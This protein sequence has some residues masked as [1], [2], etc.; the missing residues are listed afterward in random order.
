MRGRPV[1][2]VVDPFDQVCDITASLDFLETEPRVDPQRIGIWGSSYGGGHAVYVG[3]RD[4]RIQAIVAQVA[5]YRPM[6]GDEFEARA[7]SRAAGKARGEFGPIPPA[8][9]GAPGLAGTPDLAKMI[10]YRPIDT[11]ERIRVPTL[12]IDAER[13]DLFDREQNGVALYEIVRKNTAAEYRT[14]PCRHYEIYDKYY[15][16][17]STL[18]LD[19]FTRYL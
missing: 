18:A 6:G 13:E 11:A 3:A 12:I 15:R 9:D 14:Y 16:E 4:S 17:A 7:S 8:A 19:W 10:R 5:P 1:R 2:E